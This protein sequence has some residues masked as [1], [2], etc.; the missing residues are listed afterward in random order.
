MPVTLPDAS[1]VPTEEVTLL[2]APPA[3]ASVKA[4]LAPAQTMGVPVIV[5]A[6]GNALTVTTWVAAAVPQLLVTVYDIVVLPEEMPL[7]LPA[8]STVPTEDVTLLHA[9]PAAALVK[10]VLAPAQTTGVPVMVPA[11]GNVLTVTTRIAAA[12][13]QL[14]VAV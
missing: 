9:P 7:T 2:H 11:L 4:V 13:P 14:L 12:V 3:A 10:A 1:T 6:F 5:P 8:A